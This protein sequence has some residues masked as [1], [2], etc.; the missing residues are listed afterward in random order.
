MLFQLFSSIDILTIKSLEGFAKL[1]YYVKD[2]DPY[3]LTAN[4]K[5]RTFFSLFYD[6]HDLIQQAY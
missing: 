6:Y 1:G 3:L 5:G 4:F 2:I